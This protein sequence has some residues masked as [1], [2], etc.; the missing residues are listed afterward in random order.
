LY[1]RRFVMI[2]KNSR[3]LIGLIIGL[4]AGLIYGW[5]L[6]PVEYV[7]TTPD[8][9]RI[10]YRTEYVMMVS[11]AYA[12]DDDLAL[13]QI[14]LAALGPQPPLDIVIEAI[15]YAVDNEFNRTDLETLNHLAVQ[16]RSIP[17]SPEIGWP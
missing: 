5:T 3:P 1:D 15:D 17:L 16:L 11:E 12:S 8:S 13:A 7:D 14:R 4:T 10:D 2:S 6:R 9:L